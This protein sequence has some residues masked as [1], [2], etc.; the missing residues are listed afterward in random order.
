MN[1]SAQIDRL[2]GAR[3][4]PTLQTSRQGMPSRP[5]STRSLSTSLASAQTQG[6]FLAGGD[7]SEAG[8]PQHE[9]ASD[10]PGLDVASSVSGVVR[11]NLDCIVVT[12]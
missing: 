1:L 8:L 9:G 3:T 11:Q 5:S 6:L 7:A 10:T 2:I 4:N 12:W